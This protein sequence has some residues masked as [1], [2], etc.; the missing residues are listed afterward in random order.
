[1]EIKVLGS[2][3]NESNSSGTTCFQL[4]EQILI[5]AGTIFRFLESDP[6]KIEHIFLSHAH[7]DHI[8]ELPFLIDTTLDFRKTTLKVY[9]SQETI[10]SLKSNIFNDL[11]W[12]D[13]TLIKIPGTNLPAMEYITLKESEQVDIWSFQIIPFKANH[14]VPTFGYV[15]KLNSKGLIYS[16]DTYKNGKIWKILNNDTQITSL[17][18]DVSFPSNQES[19]AAISKHLTPKDL[20][21]EL[22]KLERESVKIYIYHLKPF[23]FEKIKEEI[24]SMIPEAVILRGGETITV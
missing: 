16:G 2:Y 4:S 14:T 22:H 20:K 15:V 24:I 13:F 8:A 1:M 6:N 7:L 5:D 3:A 11:I 19:R 17:I 9:G 12:P 18:V 23:Y 21:T 10:Q